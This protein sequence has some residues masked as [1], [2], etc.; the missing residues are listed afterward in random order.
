V[1]WHG[2]SFQLIGFN[3]DCRTVEPAAR[4]VAWT[5]SPP[6]LIDDSPRS[7]HVGAVSR[8]RKQ[9]RHSPPAGRP[10]LR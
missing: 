9:I 1:A 7:L 3:V 10:L 2:T 8:R 6:A 5:T 4:N